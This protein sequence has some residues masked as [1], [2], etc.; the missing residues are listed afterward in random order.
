MTYEQAKRVAWHL[1]IPFCKT[2]RNIRV[3]IRLVSFDDLRL[4]LSQ[5]NCSLE[6]LPKRFFGAVKKGYSV[7]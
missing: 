6:E 7:I 1:N 4:L 3:H 2:L 5:F